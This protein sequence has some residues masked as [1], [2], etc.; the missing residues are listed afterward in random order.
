MTAPFFSVVMAVHDALPYLKPAM[1]SILQQT[2]PDFELIVVDD[3]SQDG[4]GQWLGNV[5]DARLRLFQA[6]DRGQTPALNQGILQARADWIVR[7]DGDDWSDPRR[8]TLQ[9]SAINRSRDKIVMVTSDYAVCDENLSPVGT[10]RLEAP[11]PRLRRY[12]E[13]QNNPFCHPTV[14]FHRP[15][16][17]TVGLYDTATRNAQDYRLWLKLLDHGSWVHVPEPLL[18]YRVL[19]DS[20]SVKYQPEQSRER[21]AIL[22]GR[23]EDLAQQTRLDQGTRAQIEATYHYKLG[24]SAWL[25]GDRCA[26]WPHLFF[27]LRG[28]GWTA[29]KSGVLWALSA[30]M[31]RRLYLTLAGYRG[32]YA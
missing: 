21:R 29:L 27:A 22:Q 10:V 30:V 28:G 2:D 13:K 3:H 7:M 19:K 24:F 26:A 6:T 11:N 14:I 16:A 32:V 1:E 17:I 8:L 9:R 12:V 18:K 5:K 15:T 31:P 4:T 20:L 23:I 25:A